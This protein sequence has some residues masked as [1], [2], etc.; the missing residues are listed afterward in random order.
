MGT[1]S[2]CLTS[3]RFA[4]LSKPEGARVEVR[5]Q[6]QQLPTVPRLTQPSSV[7]SCDSILLISCRETST[8]AQMDRARHC[9][10]GA[11]RLLAALRLGRSKARDR[12]LIRGALSAERRKGFALVAELV[13]AVVGYVPESLSKPTR[14]TAMLSLR[15]SAEAR[16]IAP[17]S[18]ARL[19]RPRRPNSMRSSCTCS[20]GRGTRARIMLPAP[21]NPRHVQISLPD[22][23]PVRVSL[24]AGGKC[25]RQGEAGRWRAPSASVAPPPRPQNGG[26]SEPLHRLH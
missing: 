21:P 7:F 1:P 4:E 18:P 20:L 15:A 13:V 19:R 16:V 26:S 17:R 11:S 8:C 5:R 14:D 10:R 23:L 22:A 12:R 9:R 3:N 24:V 25:F 2:V 6:I